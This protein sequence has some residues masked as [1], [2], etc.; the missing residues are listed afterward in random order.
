MT[1]TL[2]STLTAEELALMKNCSDV[3]AAKMQ[4]D[5]KLY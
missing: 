1:R 4:E 5:G 3:V 2:C